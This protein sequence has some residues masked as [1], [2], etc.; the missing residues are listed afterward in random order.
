MTT[1]MS[2]TP[3][4]AVVLFI[5]DEVQ[6]RRLIRASLERN[7][8]QVLEAAT[9]EEGI[10]V[11]IDSQPG[12]IILDLG[13][14]DMDGMAVLRRLREWSKVPVI[15]LS[16]R[17]RESDKVLALDSG[18]NDY[19]SKPFSTNE[20]LARLRVIQRY[21]QPA[22]KPSIF[23]S[24][25]LSVDLATRTVKVRGQTVKLARTE[26]ALLRYFVQHAGR[27][28]T[29]SQLL[30]EIWDLDDVEKTARLRVYVTYLREK[31]ETNPA[32][33]QLLITV[34]GVGYRLNVQEN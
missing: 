28:L 6:M 33:P 18:A 1:E 25:H 15:V 9:G 29:H 32:K 19:L 30:R 4:K 7:G 11:A 26:Y 5:D 21:D 22:E 12:V 16:V 34:P 3:A 27:V 24:G 10:G 23:T 31:L 14:P 17:D 8:Y 20:L 2:S 13:L